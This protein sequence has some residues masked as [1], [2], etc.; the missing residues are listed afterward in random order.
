[1][2]QDLLSMDCPY[3]PSPPPTNEVSCQASLAGL[4]GET[5]NIISKLKTRCD[6]YFVLFLVIDAV[7]F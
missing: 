7:P 6:I 1:M 3:P 5:Q 2:A 4:D